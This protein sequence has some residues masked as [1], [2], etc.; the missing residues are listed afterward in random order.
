MRLL[1]Y[2]SLE[3]N[4]F[5]TAFV[6]AEISSMIETPKEKLANYQNNIL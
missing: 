2:L 3:T 6:N 5:I 4:E 1:C